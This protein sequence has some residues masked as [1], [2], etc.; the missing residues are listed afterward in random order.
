LSCEKA[1]AYAQY[2]SIIE[3]RCA[4]SGIRWKPIIY[5]QQPPVL[6]TVYDGLKLRAEARKLHAKYN[7][8]IVHCRSYIP[9]L[10]GLHMTRKLKVPLSSTCVDFGLMKELMAAYGA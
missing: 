3:A 2:A 1:D 6:S 7:F 5:H 9:A 10:I 4:K 8:A